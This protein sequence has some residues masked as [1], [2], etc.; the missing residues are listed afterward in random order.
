MTENNVQ[1]VPVDDSVGRDRAPHAGGPTSRTGALVNWVMG[2]GTAMPAI[3]SLIAIALFFQWRS[4]Y[5]LSP[6]NLGNLAVQITLVAIIAM[7]EVVVLLL[8]EIDLSLGSLVGVT[9]AIL[10]VLMANYG[11]PWYLAVP[12]MILC[13]AGF[14]AFQGA[15][16]SLLGIPS[17]VVTLA[18]LMAFLGL[19]LWILGPQ[20]TMSVFD[21]TI[22]AI[23][24]TTLPAVASWALA[25]GLV[26]AILG[27]TVAAIARRRRSARALALPLILS[28]LALV[29]TALFNASRGVP[30][31]FLLLLAMLAVGWW[32]TERTVPG[33]HLFAVGGNAEA[34]RRAGLPV[35][36]IRLL[37]FTASGMLAAVGGLFAVSYNGSAGT[38]TGGGTLLLEAIGAAVIGGTS[39]I[40]GRGTMWSALLGALI[41]GGVSNGLDLM[42][43]DQPVKYMV[44]GAIVLFA[45]SLDTILRRRQSRGRQPGGARG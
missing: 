4:Q 30:T 27:S 32:I 25:A 7:G 37:A 16:I 9:A 39:L 41:M 40:G 29:V 1:A 33:R 3:V 26:A 18:G 36:K 19:Q 8:G 14:G 34:S 43:A 12:I 6:T 15:W 45:V 17:F 44:Q 21:P 24:G 13:G 38:L 10:G 20:G 28:A 31:A 11:L 23:T 5:F 2:R 42:E 35:S 22:A